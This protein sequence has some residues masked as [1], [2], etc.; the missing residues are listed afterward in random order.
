VMEVAAHRLVP[1]EPALRYHVFAVVRQLAFELRFDVGT[2][3]VGGGRGGAAGVRRCGNRR[4]SGRGVVAV[5]GVE[6]A[7]GVVW[8]QIIHG[9]NSL[10][11]WSGGRSRDV[12][13][14]SAVSS[15]RVLS[16]Y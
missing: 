6:A 16:C 2:V 4:R 8:L 11:G 15:S 14:N 5:A 7:D 13:L 10:A 9:Y 3:D 1:V 12:W